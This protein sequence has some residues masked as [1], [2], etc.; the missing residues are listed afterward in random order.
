MKI[1]TLRRMLRASLWLTALAPAVLP[2][3]AQAQVPA[4]APAWQRNAVPFYDTVHALQGI[5]GHWALPRAQDFD[6]GASALVPAVAALCQAPA[7][8][9]K[10]ALESARAAWQATARSWEQLAAVSVGP[11][12][13]RR[14]QR[15]IDFTPTRPALIEKA[16]ATQPQ[17]AKAFE[18]IG[19][20]AKGLPALEWLLWTRPAQPGSPACSYAHEVAQDVA[21]ESAALAKAY[22]D[23]ATT[24]W[25]AEDEQEQSTQAVSEFV[26]QWV[27]GIERLR[28][29]QMDKPLRA[30]QGTRTPD[31]PRT[32]SGTTLAAWAATWGGLRSVTTLPASAEIPAAG[33]ALVPLEM[34]LRGKG[35]NP[36]A[37]KLRQATDKVDA[38][39]AQ[40]QKSGLQGKAAIQQTAKDLTALK[41]LAESEVAPALQVSIGFSDADGD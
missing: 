11:V 4:A 32:A 18:R 34:Y 5:Y 29:A 36:L 10:A 19:T 37:D 2:A 28:W 31:Y 7:A 22:A 13:A 20:P 14:S 1:N 17:G 3:V 24:D 27:G 15:A 6:R 21:R 8:D 16:I 39:M 40:M 33:E 12:I 35:L 38:S 25:G 23:A 41:F 9:G 30:A 26:N